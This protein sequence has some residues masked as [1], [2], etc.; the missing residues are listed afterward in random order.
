MIYRRKTH[1]ISEKNNISAKTHFICEKA[2]ILA[3]N[4]SYQSKPDSQQKSKIST[5][6]IE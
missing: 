4:A 2:I 5:S 1:F 6:R 3:K